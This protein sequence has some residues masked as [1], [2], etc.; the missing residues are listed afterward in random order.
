MEEEEREIHA[1]LIGTH[2]R[3]APP[4][5]LLR[6][7]GVHG[8]M[9]CPPTL[10]LLFATTISGSRMLL[11]SESQPHRLFTEEERLLLRLSRPWK[12]AEHPGT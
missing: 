11:N 6:I 10:R 5:V 2:P 1:M 3:L 8:A 9:P 4:F 7:L 12:A